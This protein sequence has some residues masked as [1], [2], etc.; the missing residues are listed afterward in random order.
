MQHS[1][2]RPC[3]LIKAQ[4]KRTA[5]TGVDFVVLSHKRKNSSLV[6]QKFCGQNLLLKS[7]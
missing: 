7:K 4:G 5:G 3:L 6:T 2:L 1:H